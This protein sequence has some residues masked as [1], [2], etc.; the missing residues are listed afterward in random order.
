MANE[1]CCGLCRA[2]NKVFI[3]FCLQ[4]SITWVMH[5]LLFCGCIMVWPCCIHTVGFHVM[6]W[7][8]LNGSWW[9]FKV[10]MKCGVMITFLYRVEGKNEAK[11][12]FHKIYLDYTWMDLIEIVSQG[13]MPQRY[14]LE[15]F[16]GMTWNLQ[17]I[18]D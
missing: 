5:F 17:R 1:L 12:A 11:Q 10:G 13:T 14:V 9:I 4:L 2:G 3:L 6:T 7:I 18:R 8:V 15:W 16:L